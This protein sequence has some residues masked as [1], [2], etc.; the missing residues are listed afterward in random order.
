M[1]ELWQTGGTSTEGPRF[2]VVWRGYDRHQVDAYVQQLLN[3]AARPA[4]AERDDRE[5]SPIDQQL[6]EFFAKESPQMFDV[7]LRGYDRKEV[8]RYLERFDR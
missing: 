7:V 4:D 6:A 5:L 3:A 2:S 8:D 1:E